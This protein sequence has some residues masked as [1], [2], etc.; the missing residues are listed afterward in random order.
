MLVVHH[1]VHRQAHLVAGLSQ[2]T[3]VHARRTA[4]DAVKAQLLQLLHA[5]QVRLSAPLDGLVNQ[6]LV[7]AR[8][9]FILGLDSGCG[10]HRSSSPGGFAEITTIH[11]ERLERH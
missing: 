9:L 1:P 7:G 6:P 5:W 2:G 11:A 8:A 3:D 4:L 10:R